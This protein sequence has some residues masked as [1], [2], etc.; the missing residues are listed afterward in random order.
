MFKVL[1]HDPLHNTHATTDMQAMEV[2]SDD[3]RLFTN[4]SGYVELWDARGLN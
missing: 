1:S 4:F 2:K 3:Y